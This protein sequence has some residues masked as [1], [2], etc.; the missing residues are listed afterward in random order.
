MSDT[1]D[2]AVDNLSSSSLVSYNGDIFYIHLQQFP[3]FL[4]LK[5]P[6]GFRLFFSSFHLLINRPRLLLLLYLHSPSSD[7]SSL[8]K[9]SNRRFVFITSTVKVYFSYI[10]LYRFEM[11]R[12]RTIAFYFSSNFI[13]TLRLH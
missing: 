5:S 10:K 1:F 12:K 6:L 13:S 11:E 3:G 7:L 8:L 9:S 4:N 2:T